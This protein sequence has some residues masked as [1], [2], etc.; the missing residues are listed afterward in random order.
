MIRRSF[1]ALAMGIIASNASA[2]P[3]TSPSAVAHSNNVT[4]VKIVCAENGYC[5]QVGRRKPVAHWVYEDGNFSGSYSGQGWYGSPRLHY[6][7][8]PYWWY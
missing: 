7:W 2:M 1:F 3:L 5:A 6:G 8:W 4:N